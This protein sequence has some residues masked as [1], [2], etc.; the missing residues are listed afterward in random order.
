[1]ASPEHGRRFFG[2]AEMVIGGGLVLADIVSIFSGAGISVSTVLT[3]I[4]GGGIFRDGK[5]RFSRKD[6]NSN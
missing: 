3:A 6:T 2:G 1:M 4:I 5:L